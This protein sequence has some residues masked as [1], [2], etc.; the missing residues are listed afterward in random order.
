MTSDGR[1]SRRCSACRYWSDLMGK[2]VDGVTYAVCLSPYQRDTTNKAVALYR[3]EYRSGDQSCR[4]W[5]SGHL[6][7]IDEPGSDPLR[8]DVERCEL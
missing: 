6:G 5:Q 7:A 8:Y 3:G 1:S 4:G 2:A